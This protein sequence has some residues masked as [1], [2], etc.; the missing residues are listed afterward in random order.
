[1]SKL[2]KLTFYSKLQDLFDSIP[3]HEVVERI[4]DAINFIDKNLEWYSGRIP[5][6]IHDG[7]EALIEIRQVFEDARKLDS[8]WS[9]YLYHHEYKYHINI[10]VFYKFFRDYE[11]FVPRIEALAET[12]HILIRMDNIADFQKVQTIISNLKYTFGDAVYSS[13]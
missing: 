12:W 4:D 11:D 10:K 5:A 9:F 7:H 3:P 1:M 13:W 6:E 2:D 8:S